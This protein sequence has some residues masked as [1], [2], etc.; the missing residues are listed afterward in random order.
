MFDELLGG[1]PF[2]AVLINK[3]FRYLRAAGLTSRASNGRFGQYFIIQLNLKN[4][5]P[6]IYFFFIFQVS[7]LSSYFAATRNLQHE[8]QC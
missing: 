6:F 2:I 4:V 8:V 1:I 3:Q 5:Q 7:G